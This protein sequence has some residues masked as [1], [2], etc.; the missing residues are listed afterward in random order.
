MNNIYKKRKVFVVSTSFDD[1]PEIERF[2]GCFKKQSYKSLSLIIVDHGKRHRTYKEFFGKSSVIEV[3]KASSDL[4]WTGALNVGI[5]CALEEALAGDYI[6]TINNDCTFDKNFVS[7]IVSISNNNNRCIVGSFEVDAQNKEFVA[8]VIRADWKNGVFENVLSVRSGKADTLS[9]KG[10]L[11]PVEVFKKIGVLDE[12]H[13]P[14]YGSDYE[15]F[16]RAKRNGYQLLSSSEVKVYCDRKRTGI[17]DAGEQLSLIRIMKLAFS[18]KS[19]INLLDHVNLVHFCCPP[20]YKA[21]NYFF[22]L[23]K[24][25]YLSSRVYPFSIARKFIMKIKNKLLK[26]LSTCSYK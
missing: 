5:S 25:V 12:K 23:E 3:I 4:W 24:I 8:G 18:K 19:Q 14:H 9:T 7:K 22:L 21:R 17:S 10:T 26:G 1:F 6:L 13:F 20:K 16:I 2:I 15:F 11:I